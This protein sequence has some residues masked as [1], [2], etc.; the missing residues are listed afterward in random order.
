MKQIKSGCVLTAKCV[1]VQLL[2]QA[3]EGFAAVYKTV[4][5][6]I[7]ASIKLVESPMPQNRLI[8]YH[9]DD[10]DVKQL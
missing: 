1:L 5:T 9:D 6:H 10:N 2:C 7:T 3:C 4:V 8:K